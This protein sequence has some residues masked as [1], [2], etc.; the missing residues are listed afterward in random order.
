MEQT[1]TQMQ[2]QT[3][4]LDG[5]KLM[6][7]KEGYHFEGYANTYD[8]VD[9]YGDEIKRGAYDG[10]LEGIKAGTMHRP[11][12]LVGHDHSGIPVGKITNLWSDDYGLKITAE[13]TQGVSQAEDLRH[14]IGHK[15]ISGLSIGYMLEADDFEYK[16]N[17]GRI[18]SRVASLPEVSVVTIPSNTQSRIDLNNI[19]SAMQDFD[20][21]R[22]ME[23]YLKEGCGMSDA[24]AKAFISKSAQLHIEA[25][26]KKQQEDIAVKMLE[27]K[28]TA[29]KLEDILNRL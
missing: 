9:S 11:A 13:L 22:S 1:P 10:I 14:A 3:L 21:I 25:Y 17:G 18:I 27:D 15:T 16:E 12:L 20:S 26:L 23:R 24:A 6:A 8:N 28:E 29:D 2:T 19:R 4:S 7:V 5:V